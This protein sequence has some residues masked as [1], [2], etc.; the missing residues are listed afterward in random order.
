MI[1]PIPGISRGKILLVVF[2]TTVVSALHFLTPAGTH[3]WT[4]FHIFYQ[5]L[6]YIPLLMAA[7]FL[8][9]W[10]TLATTVIVSSIFLV[11]VIKDWSGDTMLRAELIGEI[12]SFWV[13]AVASSLLFRRE[14]RALEKTKM[15]NEETLA[16]LAS[17]LDLREHETTL[18]SRRVREY[19]LLLARRMGI[20][21]EKVLLNMGMGALLH[22]VGKIG[23]HDD[24]LLKSGS[25]SEKE[26]KE[27]Q[28]HPELGASL[29]GKIGFLGSAREIV[30][31]H[32]EKF[33]GSGYPAGLSGQEIPLGARIFAVADVFDA[34][35]TDRP[36]RTPISY[37]EARDFIAKESGKHFDPIV[38]DVFLETSFTDWADVA[39]RSGVTL[40]ED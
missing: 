2:T 12:G 15:A 7:A 31:S 16:A 29:I 14:H 30:L 19:T 9:A 37:R 6:F 3:A 23:I 34:L 24:V 17:S 1:S 38:V 4:W 13:I 18:H 28:R 35:T 11:H 5:K 32:H 8:G 33:D 10:G 26:A 22:D 21:G 36:Y 25:L 40:S 27:M 39:S 20:R